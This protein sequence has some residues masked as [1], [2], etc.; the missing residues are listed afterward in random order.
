MLIE[1]CL[2]SKF[3]MASAVWYYYMC[4]LIE[5]SD[6]VSILQKQINEVVNNIAFPFSVVYK[7]FKIYYKKIEISHSKSLAHLKKKKKVN[8]HRILRV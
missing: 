4:K 2:M 7:I 1:S 8:I 3:Q 5:L 6:T